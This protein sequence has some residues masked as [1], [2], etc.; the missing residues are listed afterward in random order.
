[1]T[2]PAPE[3]PVLDPRANWLEA[4]KKVI[5][6]TDLAALFGVGYKDKN[7][8]TVWLDKTGRAP[9]DQDNDAFRMGRRFERPVLEEYA[10]REH[11][12]LIY[13]DSHS[14]ITI[15]EYPVLGATLDAT[16]ADNGHP[17]DAKN[18]SF[19]SAEFGEDG[20][21]V[22]PLKYMLQL[23]AQMIVTK[24]D[25]AVLAVL[26]NRYE[27]CRYNMALDPIV[28]ER[29]LERATRFMTDYVQTDTPP[30]VDGS[31]SWTEWLGSHFKQRTKVILT[32]G[33]VEHEFAV[34][35]NVTQEQVK[36]LEEEAERL[37]NHL[38]LAI[39]E[40]AGMEAPDWRITWSQSKDRVT[41]D[42][43]AVAL[44]MAAKF[45]Q[46]HPSAPIGA[47]VLADITPLHTITKPGSRSFR[48]TYHEENPA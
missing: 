3:A 11:C 31:T 21:D 44:E 29:V 23:T 5:T 33:P 24:T 35:L 19:R 41:I 7:A 14:L 6:G 22:M 43:Q 32:A 2:D 38:K 4:R 37:K 10:D 26:F 40:A 18:L 15:P 34:A 45:P 9:A 48:F 30:P 20:S 42:W 12:A 1:M 25:A 46:P 27:F 39:G 47:R 16:R 28:V 17:V 8:M 36:V 13:A